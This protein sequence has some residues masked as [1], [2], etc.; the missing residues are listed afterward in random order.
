MF[1]WFNEVLTTVCW[2]YIFCLLL[3]DLMMSWKKCFQISFYLH[4]Y[5]GSK[6]S[7]LIWLFV[8][9]I[10]K[11]TQWSANLS[12]SH[13]YFSFWII[14]GQLWGSLAFENH[15]RSILGIICGLGIICCWGSFAVLYSTANNT[16]S[17]TS[18]DHIAVSSEDS[19]NT[20]KAPQS[21]PG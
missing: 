18:D 20:M 6:I 11:M 12:Q 8:I 7:L 21:S 5:L 10:I 13:S 1:L 14:C 9:I 3:F 15:L 4:N 17:E 19:V 2:K 16:G